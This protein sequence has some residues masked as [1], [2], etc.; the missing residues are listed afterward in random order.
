[1]KDELSAQFKDEL[2]S[3]ISKMSTNSEARTSNETFQSNI[4]AQITKHNSD[5][6]ETMK[7]MR[8]MMQPMQTFIEST[9]AIRADDASSVGTAFR[10]SHQNQSDNDSPGRSS[11]PS[12]PSSQLL[13]QP[14]KRNRTPLSKGHL[15]ASKLAHTGS[16]RNGGRG[17]GGRDRQAT[18]RSPP[19]RSSRKHVQAI[20]F[21]P[22]EFDAQTNTKFNPMEICEPRQIRRQPGIPPSYDYNSNT[23]DPLA[24]SNAHLFSGSS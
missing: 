14:S 20:T 13:I 16:G 21:D 10:D 12:S 2:S 22:T 5:M 17:R 11:K 7:S 19:R 18:S 23:Y 15:P 24:E 3:A 4:T 1:M 8:I 9:L 6:H